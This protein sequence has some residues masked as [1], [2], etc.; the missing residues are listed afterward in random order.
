MHHLDLAER[1]TAGARTPEQR[2]A[3]SLLLGLPHLFARTDVTSRWY[4]DTLAAA[5]PPLVRWDRIAAD[6]DRGLVPM[7]TGER[8]ALLLAASIAGRHPV[9]LAEVLPL[10]DDALAAGLVVALHTL[11]T[12]PAT[13]AADHLRF[14]GQ[15]DR[16]AA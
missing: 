4:D 12:R 9:V 13:P 16:D 15:A 14:A 10:L 7:S 2:A 1:L 11:V 3:L 8:A 5:H 6:A